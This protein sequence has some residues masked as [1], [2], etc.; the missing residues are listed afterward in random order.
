VTPLEREVLDAARL[1]CAEDDCDQPVQRIEVGHRRVDGEWVCT[2]MTAV[3]EF[4]HR[5]EVE[6]L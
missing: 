6:P 5:V 4:G 2:R 1:T 3:C